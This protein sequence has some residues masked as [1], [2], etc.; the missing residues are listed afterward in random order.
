MRDG[1]VVGVGV[2]DIIGREVDVPLVPSFEVLDSF[3]RQPLRYD[4]PCDPFAIYAHH[5]IGFGVDDGGRP[6]GVVV[7]R[8]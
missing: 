4:I 8:V 2:H 3:I 1:P 5:S 7:P 6:L